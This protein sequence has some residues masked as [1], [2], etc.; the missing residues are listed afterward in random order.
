MGLSFL[1]FSPKKTGLVFFILL[2]HRAVFEL[3]FLLSIVVLFFSPF[4]FFGLRVRYYTLVFGLA[5][6]N[7]RNVR[8]KVKEG[9]KEGRKDGRTESRCHGV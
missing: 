9:R 7:V 3:F 1:F 8:K 6:A 4:F 5:I 2:K